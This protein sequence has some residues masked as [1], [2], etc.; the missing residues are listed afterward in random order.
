MSLNWVAAVARFHVEGIYWDQWMFLEPM[1]K[2]EGGLALFTQQHGPHRQGI[3][4]IITSWIMDWS[5]WD[6]RVEALWVA[7]L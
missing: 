1:F 7:S 5:G 2:G 6:T 3:A 4:F